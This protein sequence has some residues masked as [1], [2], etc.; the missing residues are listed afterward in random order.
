MGL[1]LVHIHMGD[2]I[3]LPEGRAS[4]IDINKDGRHVHFLSPYKSEAK[5]SPIEVLPSSTRDAVWN[6]SL[7][8]NYELKEPQLRGLLHMATQLSHSLGFA[9]NQGVTILFI[10]SDNSLCEIPRGYM[11]GLPVTRALQVLQKVV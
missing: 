3:H 1:F 11:G 2:M 5:I 4:L 9:V 8:C 10:A 6:Q 7:R